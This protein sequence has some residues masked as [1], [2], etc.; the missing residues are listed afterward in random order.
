MIFHFWGFFFSALFQNYPGVNADLLT[1]SQPSL[2]WTGTFSW[3]SSPCSTMKSFGSISYSVINH[4]QQR[5]NFHME[6]VKSTLASIHFGSLCITFTFSLGHWRPCND[7]G[8][9]KITFNILL[10]I[11]QNSSVTLRQLP[12]EVQGRKTEHW[13]MAAGWLAD[14]RKG[15]NEGATY[16]HHRRLFQ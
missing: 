1:T 9:L 15:G 11:K 2:T 4:K 5:K 12:L 16:I 13:K 3:P 10:A 7:L 8:F 14:G 6:N